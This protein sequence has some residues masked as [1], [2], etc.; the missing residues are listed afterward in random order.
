MSRQGQRAEAKDTRMKAREE[1][2]ES[3]P[4]PVP[5]RVGPLVLFPSLPCLLPSLSPRWLETAVVTAAAAE[6][7]IIN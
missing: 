1:L 6:V 7:K 5:G 4:A 3:M 2:G